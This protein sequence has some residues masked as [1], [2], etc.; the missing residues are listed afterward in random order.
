MNATSP[1]AQILSCPHCFAE[2]PYGAL[3]CRG[4]HTEVLYGATAATYFGAILLAA[5]VT[6]IA[7]FTLRLSANVMLGLFL[8]ASVSLCIF[9][10]KAQKNRVSFV[11]PAR[12]RFF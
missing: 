11:R 5:L 7:A 10:T 2:I 12:I 3:I 9:F 8:M 6:S 1:D 4:C